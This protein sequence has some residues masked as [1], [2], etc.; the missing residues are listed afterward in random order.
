MRP[1]P[2]GAHAPV[3]GTPRCSAPT[4]ASAIGGGSNDQIV[5][6]VPLHAQVLTPV[7]D[8]HDHA[9]I[10]QRVLVGILEVTGVVEHLSRQIGNLDSPDRGVKRDRVG[11]VANAETDHKSGLGV[12]HREERNVC[13]RTLVPLARER[14]RRHGVAVRV[15]H[16]TLPSSSTETTSLTPSTSVSCR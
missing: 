9:R 16:P 5:G 8:V 11:R 1:S 10:V 13:Q 7:V 4:P 14:R 2:S 6:S 12:I 15:E 3:M